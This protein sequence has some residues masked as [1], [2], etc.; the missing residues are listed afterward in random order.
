VTVDTPDDDDFDDTTPVSD[1]YALGPTLIHLVTGIAPAELSKNSQTQFIENTNLT[2]SFFEWLKKLT[3]AAA[4]Q[5]FFGASEA[6]RMIDC[7]IKS[8]AIRG[9]RPHLDS[10]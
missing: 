1:L 7:R 3:M 4:E 10:G 2:T 9:H 6:L 8:P 5:R